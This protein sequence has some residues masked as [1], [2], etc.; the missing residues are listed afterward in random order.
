M[1][2]FSKKILIV[3]DNLKNLQVTAKILKDKGFAISL[4]QSGQ[5]ALTQI[6]QHKPDLILLDIMMPGMDGFEVCIKLKENTETKDIP[7][8]FLTAKTETEDIVRG[9]ELGGADYITKPFNKDEL[10]ARVNNHIQLKRTRDLLKK[11]IAKIC[12][13]DKGLERLISELSDIVYSNN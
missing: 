10:F 8:I 12:K 1:N 4:A 7:V 11:D 9:F 3:D 5:S 13:S 2:N 6:E